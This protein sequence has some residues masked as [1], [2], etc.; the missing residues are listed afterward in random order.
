VE[1]EVRMSRDIAVD[2]LCGAVGMPCI[3][4]GSRDRS[5]VRAAPISEATPDAVTFYSKDAE[6][7]AERIRA[8]TAGVVVC[9][10]GLRENLGDCGGKTL[11]LVAK[12]SGKE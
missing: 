8:S 4:V 7:A 3:V 9:Q 10:E 6:D 12:V 5:V 11:L 1:E 2:E